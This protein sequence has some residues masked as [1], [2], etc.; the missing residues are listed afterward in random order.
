MLQCYEYYDVRINVF[1][2]LFYTSPYIAIES[3]TVFMGILKNI[4]VLKLKSL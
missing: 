4:I 1:K 3:H 2:N